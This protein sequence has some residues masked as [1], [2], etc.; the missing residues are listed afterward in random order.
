MFMYM[1]MSVI[2]YILGG[3]GGRTISSVFYTPANDL[4]VVGGTPM[5]NLF[6]VGGTPMNKLSVVGF[7]QMDNF[8]VFEDY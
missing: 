3:G 2:K 8:L 6:V 4:L 5:N 7:T 1:F